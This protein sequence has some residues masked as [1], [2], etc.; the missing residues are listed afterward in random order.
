MTTGTHTGFPRSGAWPDRGGSDHGA[1]L[2]ILILVGSLL[3]PPQPAGAEPR[4]DLRRAAV[5][6]ALDLASDV[7]PADAAARAEAVDA[8][9]TRLH[10]VDLE[11]ALARAGLRVEPEHA[12]PSLIA[13]RGTAP[14]DYLAAM[15]RSY[16]CF[17]GAEH[18]GQRSAMAL[19]LSATRQ[20]AEYAA[21]AL[22]AEAALDE[23][24]LTRLRGRAFANR[25]APAEAESFAREIKTVG[26]KP[27]HKALLSESGLT[28]DE[29]DAYSEGLFSTPPNDYGISLT[30]FYAEIVQFRRMLAASLR[31]LAEG[32]VGVQGDPK[33]NLFLLANPRD[34]EETIDLLIHRIA[35]PA[36]WNVAVMAAEPDA[37]EPQIETV[38]AGRHYRVRL[39]AGGQM[40]VASVVIPIGPIGEDTTARFAV[41]GRIGSELLGGMIH[42]LHAPAILPDLELPSIAT[43]DARIPIAS[44]D[45]KFSSPLPVAAGAGSA[46]LAAIAIVLLLRRRRST[47]TYSGR[48]RS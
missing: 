4:G 42:E 2:T 31:S 3:Q 13:A 44:Q 1:L 48:G 34:R 38:R 19:H 27:E 30:E 9:L 43:G 47:E 6:V 21:E 10:A 35:M 22:M 39:P 14:A 18:A 33:A 37:D 12:C 32:I 16:A 26:L 11:D 20:Y 25:R 40:R 8:L 24:Q 45:S 23:E 46:L 29:V 5:E 41:E 17:L 36:S 15:R 28:A 7:A